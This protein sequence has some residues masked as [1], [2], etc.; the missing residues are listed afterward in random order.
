M[1]DIALKWAFHIID[2]EEMR[3]EQY[4]KIGDIAKTIKQTTEKVESQGRSIDRIDKDVDDL[5]GNCNVFYMYQYFGGFVAFESIN[6]FR[7]KID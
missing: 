2:Q 6:I 3:K 5:K 1:Y 4:E 7:V